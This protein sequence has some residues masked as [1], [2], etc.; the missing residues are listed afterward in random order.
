MAKAHVNPEELRRFAKDLSRFNSEL[1]SLLSGLHARMLNLEK[2]WRDQEQ[3]KFIEEFEVTMKAI[4]RFIESSNRHVSILVKK[5]G[6]I[7]D[8]L[9]QR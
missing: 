2:T 3:K 8:Y 4:S 9:Q 6:H 1:Q 7:E 5:A